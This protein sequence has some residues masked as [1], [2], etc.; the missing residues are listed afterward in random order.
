MAIHFPSLNEFEHRQNLTL[1]KIYNSYR[2]ILAAILLL[3][4]TLATDKPLVGG[5]K[6]VLFSYTIAVYLIISV[7]SLV[8]VLPKKFLLGQ[9]QLFSHFLLDL[10]AITFIVDSSGGLPSGLGVLYIVMVAASSTLLRGQVALLVAAMASIIILAD[11]FRLI[12]QNYLT[13]KDFLGSGIMGCMLF[14][15]TLFVQTLS[16]RIRK[17]REQALKSAADA[18]KL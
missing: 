6:P 12:H 15:T 5:V 1:L 2:V 16:N 9:T 3:T 13:F 7:L 8:I 14:A 11:T 4:F 18:S 17:S 10:V